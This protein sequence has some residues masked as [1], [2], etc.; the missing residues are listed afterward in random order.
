MTLALAWRESLDGPRSLGTGPDIA[1]VALEDPGVIELA[2]HPG[3]E[4]H[5]AALG[6][7]LG[8]ALP[9][10]PWGVSVAGN[11]TAIW[12]APRRWRI[13]VPREE[14]ASLA[15]ELAPG[16]AG[17][18][19]DETG[20]VTALRLVGTASHEALARTCAQDVLGIARGSARGTLLAQVPTLLVHEDL[21]TDCWLMLV[22]R[23]RSLHV[24]RALVEAA[25][26][27]DRL[28]LFRKACPP[29]V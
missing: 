9:Q 7:K 5:H 18:A 6:E 28:E 26:A 13:L 29:P 19:V 12:V 1:V 24:A 21:A 27:P 23:S 25:Q 11:R 2:L 22:P 20:A 17:I 4:S 16:N 8:L 15:A 14:A 3:A 10:T